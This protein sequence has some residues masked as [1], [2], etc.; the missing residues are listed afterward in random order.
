M[1]TRLWTDL[2][3]KYFSLAVSVKA[4]T[5]LI[6]TALNIHWS[7]RAVCC[8]FNRMVVSVKHYQI[9]GQWRR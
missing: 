5:I 1:W 3:R 4:E 7:Q 9:I 2:W 6:G 8:H